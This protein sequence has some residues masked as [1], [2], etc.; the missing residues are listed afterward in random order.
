MFLNSNIKHS[1]TTK[2][3]EYF[4][5]W[6]ITER[7]NAFYDSSHFFDSFQS[8]TLFKVSILRQHTL[9]G[10]TA[11]AMI[12]NL[13]ATGVCSWVGVKFEHSQLSV[14]SMWMKEISSVWVRTA[15]VCLFV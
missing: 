2:N 3:T 4:L 12:A 13:K 14:F 6:N 11:K 5:L 15:S 1:K 9:R 10:L 7:K 8:T